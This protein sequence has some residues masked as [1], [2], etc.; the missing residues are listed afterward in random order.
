ML[1]NIWQIIVCY[2]AGFLGV[3]IIFLPHAALGLPIILLAG[4]FLTLPVLIF[5]LLLFIPLRK[6]VLRN[7]LAW[8]LAAPFIVALAWMVV[9]WMVF[10]VPPGLSLSEFLLLPD[11]WGLAVTPF[12]WASTSSALFWFWNRPRG[13]PRQPYKLST[14]VAGLLIASVLLVAIWLDTYW[15]LKYRSAGLDLYRFLSLPDVWAFTG[16]A[17]AFIW[18]VMAS[19]LLWCR[20]GK[21]Q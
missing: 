4:A 15:Y 8:C 20:T 7:L 14:I 17:F 11:T 16:I 1:K 2:G 21:A 3:N 19:V 12:A 10:D 5:V 18:V 9:F 6:I 13:K